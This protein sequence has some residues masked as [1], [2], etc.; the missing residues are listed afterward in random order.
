ML[1]IMSLII[2]SV[3][4]LHITPSYIDMRCAN[5]WQIYIKIQ[6]RISFHKPLCNLGL[7]GSKVI[8]QILVI[9][10]LIQF[11]QSNQ[12]LQKQIFIIFSWAGVSNTSIFLLPLPYLICAV[13][14]IC[15]FHK[16]FKLQFIYIFL[17]SFAV[18]NKTHKHMMPVLFISKTFA[19]CKKGL[20]ILFK[21]GLKLA[22]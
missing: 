21:K 4:H 15:L 18:Y 3:Y 7:Q 6:S 1:S 20:R 16:P 22:T 8:L 12:I 11:G 10:V 17:I 5:L 13:I 19:M 14:E 9:N 2:S